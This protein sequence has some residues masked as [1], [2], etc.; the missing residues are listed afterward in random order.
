MLIDCET[1]PSGRGN[2]FLLD[3]AMIDAARGSGA[4]FDVIAAYLVLARFTSGKGEQAGVAT[5]AGA[6]AIQRY[7]G[8]SQARARAAV[9][10][11]VSTE[12]T[13][14]SKPFVTRG[15]TGAPRSRPHLRLEGIDPERA[16]ALPNRFIG[17]R[18]IPGAPSDGLLARIIDSSRAVRIGGASVPADQVRITALTLLLS[19]YENIDVH[20]L[21]GV[22]PAL[23][24]FGRASVAASV[25]GIFQINVA[26]QDARIEPDSITAA[27]TNVL[28]KI[29]AVRLH[30]AVVDADG[31]VAYSLAVFGP[32]VDWMPQGFKSFDDTETDDFWD[33]ATGAWIGAVGL[34]YYAPLEDGQSVEVIAC[35]SL[36]PLT[37]E[38]KAQKLAYQHRTR[39]RIEECCW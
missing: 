29:G 19:M 1:A 34:A 22:P 27:A 13:M 18:Y 24:R 28:R 25:D 6:L 7:A 23:A 15:G 9:D 16:I 37:E 30:L 17:T 36:L 21:A 35:P 2:F 5:A 20:R 8:M 32:E 10:W 39:L 26:F 3:P 14:S 11:L 38:V 33:K 31:E 12:N 4:S